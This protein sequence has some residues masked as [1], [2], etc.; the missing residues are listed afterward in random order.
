MDIMHESVLD[1]MFSCTR[2]V[3]LS[4]WMAF[5]SSCVFSIVMLTIMQKL[6]TL[7]QVEDHPVRTPFCNEI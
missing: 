5:S 7:T 3:F 1:N 2:L 4:G 6:L